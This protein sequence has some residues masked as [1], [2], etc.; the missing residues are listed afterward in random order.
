MEMASRVPKHETK[1]APWPLRVFA[2]VVAPIYVVGGTV[3]AVFDFPLGTLTA[4]GLVVLGVAAGFYAWR[5]RQPN[6]FAG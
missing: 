3:G 5:G 1:L 6:W 4:L 2:G